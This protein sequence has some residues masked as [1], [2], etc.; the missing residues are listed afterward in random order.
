MTQNAPEA[1]EVWK[2]ETNTL[3]VVLYSGS[4]SIIIN[5]DEEWEVDTFI[6]CHQLFRKANGDKP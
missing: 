2:S 4:S 1:G 3:S 5:G 6:Q